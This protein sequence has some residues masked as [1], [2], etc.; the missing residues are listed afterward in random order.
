MEFRILGPIE[1]R[2]GGRE[3]VRLQGTRQCELLAILLLHANERVGAERLIDELWSDGKPQTALNAL[4]VHVSHLRKL[5]ESSASRSGRILVTDRG[6]YRLSVEPDELDAHRFES[7]VTEGRR[8]LARGDQEHASATLLAASTLWRGPALA[9]FRDE[10]FAEAEIARLEE[11]RLAALEDRVD[12]DLALGRHAE[13]V[14]ELESLVTTNPLRERLRGQLMLALYRSGR[15]AD[16]LEE[17]QRARRVL[18]G[19]VGIEPSLGLKALQ[20]GILR[21]DPSLECGSRESGGAWS[22]G[23]SERRTITALSAAFAPAEEERDPETA[24]RAGARPFEEA[25]EIVARHG[26][27]MLEEG[28]DR[29]LAVFGLPPSS[30]DDALRALR[31]AVDLQG[32]LGETVGMGIETGP[33][34]VLPPSP[35]QPP[36]VGDVLGEVPRLA[37]AAKPAEI[38]VGETTRLLAGHALRLG[39]ARRPGGRK[40]AWKLLDFFAD[41][42][43]IPRHPT[44]PLV[45][46]ERELDQLLRAY[47][48]TV[49]E[50]SSYLV[51]VLGPAGIGKSRL[52]AEFRLRVAADASVF[53]GRCLPY[54][55]G[56]TFWPLAE[57]VEQAAGERAPGA[58]AELLGGEEDAGT[59]AER[60][61][62]ALGAGGGAVGTEET[63]W[64]VRRFLEGLARTRPVVV[65]FEDL[66]W[67]EPTFLDL[68]D[69][70]ADFARSAPL[71]LVC[72]ARPELL[73]RRPTW[74]GGKAN[75]ASML[76]EPL[77][78]NESAELIEELVDETPLASA[79]RTRIVEAA[80]G[81]PLFIEE[82]V[83]V[84]VESPDPVKELA[85]LPPTIQA[86]L[87]ARLDQ[88]EPDERAILEAASIVGK[89]FWLGAV[90][91][92]ADE[93][94]RGRLPEHLRTL[95]RKDLVRPH[96]Q[97]FAGEEAFRFRHIL[98][99]DATYGAIP[100]ERRAELHA[101]FA[102]WVERTWGDRLTEVQ[103]IVGFHLEQAF[104]YRSELVAVDAS[105]LE[106]AA[107][108]AAHL[109]G[110]GRRA[111]VREDTPA[112]ISLLSR[113][114]KL[115]PAED[116][117]RL[118]LLPELGEAFREA[119]EF[120]RAKSV[121][122]ETRELASIAGD[123]GV[124][125]YAQVIQ[126]LLKFRT[127]PDF[128][129]EEVSDDA[130]RAIRVL[131]QRGVDGWL[132]KGWELMA[133]I[134]YLA[135]R[136]PEVED[137]L[138]RVVEYARRAGDVRQE[139]RALSLLLG[140]AVFGPLRV[141]D[142]IRRCEEVLRRHATSQGITASAT[143]A[144]ASL[145]SMNGDFEQARE[146]V[147]RDKAL[148]EELG[149]PLAAAR[150]SIAYGILE[151]LAD[152]AEAAEAELRA[153]YDQ[154]T[155]F[156]EKGAL[157]HVAALLA[158]A[159]YRQERDDEALELV[160]EARQASAPEDLTV[161]VYWRGP[162]A[163]VLARQGRAIE[164]QE[165]VE[166]AV[167]IARQTDSLNLK[168]DALMD[169]AEVLRLDDQAEAAAMQ[170]RKAI[171]AYDRKGNRVAARRARLLLADLAQL[172]PA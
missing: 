152:E 6:G 4:Q 131:E 146:L 43:A 26:G 157:S 144:L 3:P 89:D 90:G 88:L 160:D 108:A 103:E 125:A 102:N 2:D 94:A 17:F 141:A 149:R 21:Q 30:E 10:P 118:E 158:E 60:I 5:L 79:N 85:H 83:R 15:Q 98:T 51:T 161:Q 36:L 64:A 68:I 114:A 117:R 159:V 132:A 80:G 53:V 142:G 13:L 50:S 49:R 86:V 75:A 95:V 140:T 134:P 123:E 154:L 8:A 37:Y 135:C 78:E 113:A 127:D 1:V 12:A 155:E 62:G 7:L 169:A 162:R 111:H 115:L 124:A 72:L 71:L 18:V 100:K 84:T 153:G 74:G 116:P 87:A 106:L 156:G 91:E 29:V 48:S 145:K 59:I 46:R 27:H 14:A 31:A 69:H 97:G 166:E 96:A 20:A 148:S 147:A 57:I 167:A 76:L 41:A 40:P 38:L 104:C 133:W 45:N 120:G 101:Q 58:L 126:L 112:E 19:E 73:D 105:V 130:K 137:A 163:K 47:E 34:L 151:L 70:V 44:I 119:G 170:I 52:A 81:N 128:P 143:R 122:D 56:I 110:A 22:H 16:A 25:T 24:A 32:A 136:A 67:A 107:R 82:L 109:A 171:N 92:L 93:R 121:L 129:A 77:S 33:V 172:A 28:A 65:F 9:D 168:G 139:S 35:G 63:F 11:L 42:P 99:R 54:G 164:A 150:A 165:L 23:R 138:E 66:H 39:A 61:S 55:D